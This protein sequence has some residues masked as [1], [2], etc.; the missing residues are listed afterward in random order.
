MWGGAAMRLTPHG[1]PSAL[2][3]RRPLWEPLFGGMAY[4]PALTLL[5]EAPRLRPP[6]LL[7]CHLLIPS[8]W[9]APSAHLP[10]RPYPAENITFLLINTFQDVNALGCARA[11]A[12]Y[13]SGAALHALNQ[14]GPC[15]AGHEE[16]GGRPGEQR[17]QHFLILHLYYAAIHAL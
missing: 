12:S 3:G 9:G 11:L 13:R 5:N 16:A 10:F 17:Q 1:E 4:G 2:L 6:G 15:L 14:T 8:P 7:G